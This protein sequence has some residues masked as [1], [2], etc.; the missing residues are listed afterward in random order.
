[1]GGGIAK[2][3][4]NPVYTMGGLRLVGSLRLYVSLAKETYKKDCILQK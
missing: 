1:M 2:G 4:L 3:V